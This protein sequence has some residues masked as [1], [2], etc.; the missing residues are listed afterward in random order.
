MNRMPNLDKK[1]QDFPPEYHTL[2]LM[3]DIAFLKY[4]IQRDVEFVEKLD[5]EIE[6]AQRLLDS[7]R[8]LSQ[9]QHE[10]IKK[11]QIELKGKEG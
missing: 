10:N 1:V 7:R 2:I 11:M 9:Q 6:C 5:Y 4:C 8:G 3:D